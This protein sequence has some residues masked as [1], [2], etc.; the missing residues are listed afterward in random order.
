[1]CSFI[2]DAQEEIDLCSRSF[3]S[4]EKPFVLE[5]DTSIEGLGAV[6]SQS[7][8][9]SLLHPVAFA[10]RSLTSAERN[11]SITELETLTVVWAITHFVPYLYGHDVTVLTDHT[12]VKAI[13]QT[14]NP[15]G[16]HARWWTKVYASGIRNVKIQYRPGR[17][18]SSADALLLSTVLPS[19]RIS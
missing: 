9:D 12:A 13:L 6:L 2:S 19:R 16:K 11:Y 8:E 15:S 3:V 17:L 1:M 10:S 7:Q 18:N 5:T 14:P 4:F